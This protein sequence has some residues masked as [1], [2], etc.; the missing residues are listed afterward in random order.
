M[1]TVSPTIHHGSAPRLLITVHG[2][3]TFGRWQDRLQQKLRGELDGPLE[4]CHY[5]FGFFTV[6]AF[7]V[8]LFRWIATRRF[9]S[10]LLHQIGRRDWSRIDIVAH[11]F[12]THLV[13]RAM[14]SLP[15]TQRPS[16][17]TVILAG[18][19]L[20]SSFRVRELVGTSV[21]RLVNECGIKDNVLLLNQIFVLFTGMAGRVGLNGMETESFRNRYFNFGHSGYFAEDDGDK[22]DFMSEYWLPLLQSQGGITPH[23]ERT[24]GM[25]DGVTTLLLNNSEPIKLACY[26]L[27]L[28][29]ALGFVNNLRLDAKH[30]ATVALSRQLSYESELLGSELLDREPAA[31]LAAES[32]ERLP[33]AAADRAIRDSI[34][35][36]PRELWRVKRGAF[37]AFGTL[38]FSPDGRYVA[39]ASSDENACVF[40]A[41]SGAKVF[42]LTLPDSVVA[43]FDSLA[44]SPDSRYLVTGDSDGAVRVLET[45][46]GKEVW[47]LKQKGVVVA[48]AYSPDGKYVASVDSQ[49][50]AQIFAAGNGKELSR[51]TPRDNIF[52]GPGHARIMG[53][54]QAVAFSPDGKL[55]ATGSADET[56][57][58]YDIFTG[59]E[60][61]HAI[62]QSW[63]V[64]VSF[65]PNGEY[66]ATASGD[67]TARVF[68]VTTGKEIWRVTQQGPVSSVIFSPDGV[69]VATA[70]E[71]KTARVFESETGREVSRVTQDSRVA[72][73]AFS[74]DGRFVATAGEDCTARVFEADSGKEVG[75]VTQPNRFLDK[76]T[77]VAFSPDGRHVAVSGTKDVARVF[78]VV[79]RNLLFLARDS[80]IDRQIT[81]SPRGKYIAIIGG[82]DES[83]KLLH[84]FE[85]R[86]GRMLYQIEEQ[87]RGMGIGFSSAVF[88]SDERYLVTGSNDKT[89]RVYQS[90]NGQEV[91][92]IPN[93]AS[94]GAV[95]FS[96][97][98]QLL[99]VAVDHDTRLL[100]VSTMQERWR[101]HLPS[102]LSVLAFSIDGRFLVIGGY[103][104]TNALIETK[105][106]KMTKLKLVDSRRSDP[107]DRPNVK[108]LV[109]SPDGHYVA[110]GSSDNTTRVF[111][112]TTGK[113]I[114]FV[115]A[116]GLVDAVA[117]S[118]DSKYV[119]EGGYDRTVRVF[120]AATGNEVVQVKVDGWVRDLSFEP[121]GEALFV[122]DDNFTVTDTATKRLQRSVVSV[123][124]HLLRP[125]DLIGEAC[126][127][128]QRNL[129]QD[130]WR[131]YVGA[132]TEFHKTCP[133]LSA[134]Q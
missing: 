31:L 3:R 124:R 29:L 100:E 33:S 106:G 103:D 123:T 15:D 84:V 36:L 69:Y 66:L 86:T 74:P 99:A 131:Q 49:N 63:V 72:A 40:E 24:P 44:F 87:D 78:E 125:K 67:N 26:V 88:S 68:Q 113:E 21:S 14:L 53:E 110:A 55:V 77:G 128:L 119:A 117:F 48:V 98:A 61:W 62:Q 89:V 59:K 52:D 2:I 108:A 94:V 104:N 38:V 122:A 71:D 91:L 70:A 118:Q 109:F 8:P 34:K 54:Y 60:I 56:A 27:P 120:E 97:D 129:T 101:V 11:S 85:L 92:S 6:I 17:H 121:G 39:T 23:D 32:M 95:A 93:P 116:L 43:G 10:E 134:V 83:S 51:L 50:D 79:D 22:P 64:A 102:P 90:L 76:F 132:E 5:R 130:E 111:D 115:G 58:V 9:R 75:R 30:Q 28:L 112:T 25:F 107:S 73:V 96:P 42:C 18:S 126:S 13:A 41:G 20:R 4:I 105:T 19:V 57:R 82:W 65:S 127:R 114:S 37:A 16:I 1:Q 47:H 80:V 12:G 45:A 46:T 35:L 7:L 133:N 81:L